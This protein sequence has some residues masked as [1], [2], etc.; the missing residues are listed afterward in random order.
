MGS[1]RRPGAD[2]AVRHGGVGQASQKV[3]TNLG[4][5]PMRD[6]ATLRFSTLRFSTLRSYLTQTLAST[7]V[8][9][10]DPYVSDPRT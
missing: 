10:R 4:I 1:S 5:M 6:R 2:G 8:S 7:R 9:Y 3:V